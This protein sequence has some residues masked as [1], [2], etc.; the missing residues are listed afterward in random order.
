MN[1]F[2]CL[3]IV[4]MLLAGYSLAQQESPDIPISDEKIVLNGQ[5]F[6]LHKVKQGQTMYSI[7]KAY[8][9]K[10]KELLVHNPDLS[11][12]LKTGSTIK[13]PVR[14]LKSAEEMQPE[15]D[16]S[17]YHVIKIRRKHTLY[18]LSKRYDVTIQEI[19]DANPGLETNDLKRNDTVIIP[20]HALQQE[21]VDFT[22]PEFSRDTSEYVYHTIK[23][24]ETLYRIGEK[25]NVKLKHI[26]SANPD[27][28]NRDIWV[29][30]VIRIPREKIRYVV[31]FPKLN[32]SVQALVRLDTSS[33]YD[34]RPDSFVLDD[35]LLQV[36]DTLEPS[37]IEEMNVLLMLPFNVEANIERIK[38]KEKDDK[39]PGLYPYTESMVRMYEGVLLGL[40]HLDSLEGKINLTV[41]DTRGSIEETK[42]ILNDLDEPPDLIIG[43]IGKSNIETA[44]NYADTNDVNVFTFVDPEAHAMFM[45]KSLISVQPNLQIQWFF[46]AEYLIEHNYPVVIVHDGT[47][48]TVAY[49]DEIKFSI[50]DYFSAHGQPGYDNIATIA[51]S[52]EQ[53]DAV[54]NS[55]RAKDTTFVISA[56]SE[57]IFV[58]GLMNTLYQCEEKEVILLGNEQ[59]LDQN[60]VEMEEYKKLRFSYVS[61]VYINYADS[62]NHSMIQQFREYFLDEPGKYAFMGYDATLIFPLILKYG[63]NL[64]PALESSGKIE[65]HSMTLKF[66]YKGESMPLVNTAL[67]LI[68]LQEDYRFAVEYEK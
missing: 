14:P 1:R 66:P 42:T 16:T 32:D 38:E 10:E 27:L 18:S 57:K 46:I 51:Y 30:E 47:Q 22:D 31:T 24:G 29:G 61:P 56:S 7:C 52:R 35:S 33:V 67:K 26:T 36:I 64:K 54:K 17:D 45:H 39:Q 37:W 41:R 68:R 15:I 6:Y 3:T 50:I 12:G 44:L 40:E 11:R 55:L 28:K 8:N 21:K 65:G 13:I 53:K 5:K 49:A 19:Y 9:V 58:T 4:M 43:P 59:W 34:T 25:Y 23:K 20:K 63:H 62:S 60:Y 48:S 2:F